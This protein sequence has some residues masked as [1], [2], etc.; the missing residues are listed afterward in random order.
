MRS[1]W[2]DYYRFNHQKNSSDSE[3]CA[4]ISERNRFSFVFSFI[5]FKLRNKSLE[6]SIVYKTTANKNVQNVVLSFNESK[7]SLVCMQIA[8]KYPIGFSESNGNLK[9]VSINQRNQFKC[10][11]INLKA[12]RIPFASWKTILPH[13]NWQ[14]K[15]CWPWIGGKI[16]EIALHGFREN[17][18]KHNK[19]R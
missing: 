14:F 18:N 15:R 5:F 12:N 17:K 2:F 19:S 10:G 16:R 6:P 9:T 7:A 1:I 8:I 11:Y 13:R 4:I 3:S